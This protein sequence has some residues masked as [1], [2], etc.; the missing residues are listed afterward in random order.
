MGS[1]WISSSGASGDVTGLQWLTGGTP[2]PGTTATYKPGNTDGG[3]GGGFGGIASVPVVSGGRYTQAPDVKVSG[4][5]GSGLLLSATVGADGAV[6][7]IHVASPGRGYTAGGLPTITLDTTFEE[8]AAQLGTPMLLVGSNPNGAYPL[9]S[10]APPGVTAE[11]LNN[12]YVMLSS[13]KVHPS[14]VGAEY[15]A[16]RLSRNVYDAIMSL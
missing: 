6:T 9:P 13:D 5:T 12:I 16:Q 2:A 10:F 8:I 4:G 15:L 1:G 3:G 11:D 14:G 7:A